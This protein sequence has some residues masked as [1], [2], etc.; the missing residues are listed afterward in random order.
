MVRVVV[1]GGSGGLGQHIVDAILATKKHDVVVLSRS[2]KPA[3]SRRGA[4]VVPVSYTDPNSLENALKGADAVISTMV[5]YNPTRWVA[6]QLALLNAAKKAGV[7]RFAP[8]EWTGRNVPNDPINLYACRYDME[9]AVRKSGLE[10]TFFENGAFMNYLGCGTP[11]VG[12]IDPWK[13]IVD[14]E[15][16]SATIPGDGNNPIVMTRTEDIGAFVAAS[17]DLPKWPEVSRMRGDRMTYNEIVAVAEKVRG[18]CESQLNER[19]N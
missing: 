2:P 19:G 11:G 4:T 18:Q 3:L 10:F 7:R 15:N 16:C 13:L 17:L 12:Y 9:K 5:D 8:S 14:V 6:S 1:A